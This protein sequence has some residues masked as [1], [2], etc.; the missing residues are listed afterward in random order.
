MK[1]IIT[2]DNGQKM[3]L[4]CSQVTIERMNELQSIH[5][6]NDIEYVK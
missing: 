4:D 5:K 6:F 2:F 1:I 3:I